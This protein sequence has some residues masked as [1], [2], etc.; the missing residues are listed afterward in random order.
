MESKRFLAKEI[1]K[2]QEKLGGKLLGI[3]MV[4]QKILP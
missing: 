1:K 2:D 4:I 3:I